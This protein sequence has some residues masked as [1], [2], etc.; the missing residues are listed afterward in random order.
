VSYEDE[1]ASN[2]ETPGTPLNEE[3]KQELRRKKLGFEPML[4]CNVAG[5]VAGGHGRQT[6]LERAAKFVTSTNSL[7]CFNKGVWLIRDPNNNWDKF[8][9]EVWLATGRVGAQY[10]HHE[11]VGF[12]PKRACVSCGK[13]WGGDR[14]EVLSC[15]YCQTS[16]ENEPM[17]HLNRFICQNFFDRGE[18]IWYS[19]WWVNQGPMSKGGVWGCQ[20][21]LAFPPIEVR[22][23]NA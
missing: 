9:I 13:S 3:E 4:F 19:V 14:S 17:S 11:K 8:A 18:G 2:V 5:V 22:P 7:T 21:A 15:P 12:I 16:L 23:P 20:L 10:T 1:Y 6:I